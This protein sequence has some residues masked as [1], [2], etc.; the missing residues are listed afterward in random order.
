[1]N[2]YMSSLTRE[3]GLQHTLG[4][5]LSSALLFGLAQAGGVPLPIDR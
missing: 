1:M 4:Q 3:L 2:D 5:M